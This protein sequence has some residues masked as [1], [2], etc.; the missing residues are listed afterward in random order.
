MSVFYVYLVD[1]A[2]MMRPVTS[3]EEYLS[4]RGSEDQRRTLKTVR[5]RD[6]EQKNQ[7]V[8]MN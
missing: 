4:L 3:R 2:K 1:G 5:E 7:L 6:A 8:Q